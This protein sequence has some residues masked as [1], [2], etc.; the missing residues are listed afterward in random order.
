MAVSQEKTPRVSIIT[1]SYEDDELTLRFIS[2]LGHDPHVEI[3]VVDNSKNDSLK[4]KLPKE[5]IYIHPGENKG[6]GGALNTGYD[7]SRGEWIM[8]LNNDIETSIE[9]V[10]ELVNRT[11]EHNAKL[12][13]PKLILPDGSTQKSVGYFD[14]FSSHFLNGLFARPRFIDPTN[15]T[16]KT[17]VDVVT[18]ASMLFKREV[19]EKVGLFDEYNFFMYFEDIDLCMRLHKMDMSFLFVPQVQMKHLQ[20][21]TTNKDTSQKKQNY[22]K[23]VHAY[24]IKHRGILIA[25]LAK[26]LHIYK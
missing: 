15:I 19:I 22:D 26:L 18:G 10:L 13:T 7:K 5:I 9:K 24:L 16:K 3:I 20:S 17:S 8:I 4:A 1:V 12:A 14:H 21:V 6:Y 23:S 25:L 2:L 11:E